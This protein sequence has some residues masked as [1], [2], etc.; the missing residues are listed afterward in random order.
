MKKK[1]SRYATSH[2]I[3]NQ[4]EHGSRGRVLR[5][6]LSIKSV[7][8]M[9]RFEKE[10]QV[11]AIDKLT[12]LYAIDHCFKANDISKIHKVWLNGIY[13]WAGEYRQVKMSKDDFSFAFPEQIPK[14]IKELEK[15]P[16]KK[17]TPCRFKTLE[18]II[19]AL[20]IVHTE[21]VIIHPFRDG[22]GRV[23]RI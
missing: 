8:E 23:A 17:Y 20:A 11:L 12:D 19:S 10:E 4:Y 7:R 21:L 16:F 14:L 6:K 15:G 1:S 22:N 3:E 2:L 13:E 9:N 18:E 5:N